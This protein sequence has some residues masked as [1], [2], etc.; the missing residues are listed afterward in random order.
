MRKIEKII[1]AQTFFRIIENDQASEDDIKKLDDFQEVMEETDKYND[2][3]VGQLKENKDTYDN[4]MNQLAILRAMNPDSRM[5]TLAMARLAIFE[6]QKA[7]ALQKNE[8]KIRKLEKNPDVSAGYTNSFVLILS[9]LA[10]GILMG[11]VIFLIK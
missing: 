2:Y 7:K 5:S 6:E 8:N 3:K 10:T 9:V 11:I 4:K 1:S